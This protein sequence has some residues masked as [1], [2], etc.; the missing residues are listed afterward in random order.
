MMTP[1][2][3]LHVSVYNDPEVIISMS[4]DEI[5]KLLADMGINPTPFI[6]RELQQINDTQKK[7]Q[8]ESIFYRLKKAVNTSISQVANLLTSPPVFAFA[9]V[10]V[11]AVS[12]YI[13][14]LPSSPKGLIDI[15]YDEVISSTNSSALRIAEWQ[16][17]SVTSDISSRHFSESSN[18]SLPMQAFNTGLW[19]GRQDLR[20]SPSTTM[21][22]NWLKKDWSKTEWASYFKLGRW[23][24]LLESVCQSIFQYE[25]PEG[26]WEKQKT[27]FTQLNKEFLEQQGGNDDINDVALD[28]VLSSFEEEIRPLLEQ[29]PN[30][31]RLYAKLAEELKLMREGLT[32]EQE[33]RQ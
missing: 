13:V 16:S 27:I 22:E 30:E 14:I 32:P 23:T 31:P 21:D 24:F 4:E 1:L 10:F 2:E 19:K 33:E 20:P 28:W 29:L 25:V 3:K 26:F 18:F 15:S 11:L 5:D 8:E 17:S 12:L 9:A 6:E 7:W